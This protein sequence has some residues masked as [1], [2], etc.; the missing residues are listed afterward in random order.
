MSRHVALARYLVALGT[1]PPVVAVPADR[2]RARAVPGD[3]ATPRA[4]PKTG[5][6]AVVARARAF[7]KQL[8]GNAIDRTLLTREFS[9]ELKPDLAT[10]M[11]RGLLSLG[12]PSAF[13][14]RGK[15]AVD[16]VT[17]YD[18]AVTF[19]AGTIAITIG[20]DDTSDLIARYYVR[21]STN[22]PQ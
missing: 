9:A 15:H 5:D 8:Q 14:P 19:P 16:G 7:F 21:R 22:S 6:A 20:I 4:A 3:R 13:T 10:T 12:E 18:Y 1:A 11:A 2:S 17:T